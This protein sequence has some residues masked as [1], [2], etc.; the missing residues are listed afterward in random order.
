MAKK[1]MTPVQAR[2]HKIMASVNL[3]ALEKAGDDLDFQ[4]KVLVYIW[5]EEPERD[6]QRAIR[7]AML[8]HTLVRARSEIRSAVGTFRP[9]I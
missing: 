4:I 7:R 8:L 2:E 9:L 3:N 5:A 1:K 6:E